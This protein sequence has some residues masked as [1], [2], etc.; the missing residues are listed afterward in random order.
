MLSV[1][2]QLTSL[3]SLRWRLVLLPYLL[4]VRR[5]EGI[6]GTRRC[7]TCGR[8]VYKDDTAIISLFSLASILAQYE[9]IACVSILIAL[10]RVYGPG[11][12]F[13]G[14]GE[15]YDVRR[16]TERRQYLRGAKCATFQ[17]HLNDKLCFTIPEVVGLLTGFFCM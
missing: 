5:S 14:K 17:A 1:L 6:L 4:A 3:G 10:C 8:L 7:S 9:A 12:F 11:I 13:Y 2:A 16:E 15:R